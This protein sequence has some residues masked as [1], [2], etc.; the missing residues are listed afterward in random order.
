M[1]LVGR[2]QVSWPNTCPGVH[3]VSAD[4]AKALDLATDEGNTT[5]EEMAME[6]QSPSALLEG[7]VWR[8]Q[9]G[10]EREELQVKA[11]ECLGPMITG[12]LSSWPEKGQ[13]A[14]RSFCQVP[15]NRLGT[16]RNDSVLVRVGSTLIN[17]NKPPFPQERGIAQG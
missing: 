4:S 14:V 8:P 11:E 9:V 3:Q 6:T 15:R 13:F 12:E 10:A 7:M 2:L 17:S 5:E 1:G 16:N